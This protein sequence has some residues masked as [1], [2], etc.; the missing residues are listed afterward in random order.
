M[1]Q[2]NE[3]LARQPY[4]LSGARSPASGASSTRSACCISQT[5]CP[6]QPR[7]DEPR[8]SQHRSRRRR[9]SRSGPVG[10]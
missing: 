6:R 4:A 1:A 8:I 2:T 7:P 10:P 9:R 3:T 5:D